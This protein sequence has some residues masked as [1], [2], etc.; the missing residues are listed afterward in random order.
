MQRFVITS[1]LI[2][3]L[4]LGFA[5]QAA[6][7]TVDADQDGR[8]RE[9]SANT[10]MDGG[11]G[12]ELRVQDDRST[13]QDNDNKSYVR[14]DLDGLLPDGS[15]GATFTWIMSAQDTSDC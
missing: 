12:V 1:T 6:V 7:M 2:A 8:I 3:C 5:A 10:I 14:F 4:S 15:A 9:G 11:V 13:N